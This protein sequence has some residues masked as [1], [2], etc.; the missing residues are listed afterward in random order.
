[1]LVGECTFTTGIVQLPTGVSLVHNEEH[2][3]PVCPCG[4]DLG[5]VEMADHFATLPVSTNLPDD[6]ARLERQKA[7][8]VEAAAKK[9]ADQEA[10]APPP[11]AS[12]P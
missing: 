5:Y 7:A 1:M 11:T 4:G 12:A 2:D 8:A 6:I 3:I 10:A 9:K